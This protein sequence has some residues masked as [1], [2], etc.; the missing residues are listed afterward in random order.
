VYWQGRKALES[1]GY[2][3]QAIFLDGRPGVR[4]IF[5][6]IPVQMCH[7]HQKQ[8]ITRYLTNNP[9]LEAGIELKK[10]TKTLCETNEDDF[11][12]AINS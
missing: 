9:K 5:S 2:T 3:L 4:Q 7:F 8:I 10:L 12:S 11:V 6:D 1:K